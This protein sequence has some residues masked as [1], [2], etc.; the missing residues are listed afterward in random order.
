MLQPNFISNFF[1]FNSRGLCMDPEAH[2]HTIAP[3]SETAVKTMFGILQIQ[4][5]CEGLRTTI[6][7]E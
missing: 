3:N 2:V 7:N 6:E 5:G 4:C 1:S